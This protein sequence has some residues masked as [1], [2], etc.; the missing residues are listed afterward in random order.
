[1]TFISL[2][3]LQSFIHTSCTINNTCR[4][5]YGPTITPSA[6]SSCIRNVLARQCYCGKSV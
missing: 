5:N 6:A 2:V 3:L 1:M 4:T